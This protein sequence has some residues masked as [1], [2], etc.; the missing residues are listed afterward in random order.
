MV[1]SGGLLTTACSRSTIYMPANVTIRYAGCF[2]EL[3]PPWKVAVALAHYS[4]VVKYS[5]LYNPANV[6]P[7][8]HPD[9]LFYICRIGEPYPNSLHWSTLR[10]C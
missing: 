9:H 2:R 5:A 10:L 3:Q 1:N 8:P 7:I 4:T 6:P